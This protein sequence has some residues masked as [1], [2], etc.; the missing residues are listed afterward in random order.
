MTDE[1]FHGQTQVFIIATFLQSEIRNITVQC[2]RHPQKMGQ[3]I[4]LSGAGTTNP[5]NYFRTVMEYLTV[6]SKLS[7]GDAV[8]FAGLVFDFY[9]MC[10][11]QGQ[12]TVLWV[13][14]LATKNLLAPGWMLS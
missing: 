14:V 2:Y 12:C 7:V 5:Q 8:C 4:I 1:T 6:E 9:F 11:R 13:L 10:C 3:T